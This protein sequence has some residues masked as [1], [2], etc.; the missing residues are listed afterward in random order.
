[1]ALFTRRRFVAALLGDLTMRLPAPVA[2]VIVAPAMS[3]AEGPVPLEPGRMTAGRPAG[4]FYRVEVARA[5]PRRVETKTWLFLPGQRVSRVYPYG[6]AF[7]PSRCG[8]DTCGSYQIA[9]SQLAVRF[10]GGRV[11]RWTFAA[12]ADGISLDGAAYRPADVMTEAALVGRWAD[13]GDGGSNVYAFDGDRRFSFGTG[14]GGLTGTY[15]VQG[16]ALTLTF[17]D[18]DVRRRTLFAASTGGPVGMISV[19]G[20]GYARK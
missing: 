4:L 19:D 3:R 10:D 16:F 5:G 15:Q 6:G 7:D 11:L 1:M 18:G 17:A 12:N 13:A 2:G 9:A 14:Q 20:E 8:P